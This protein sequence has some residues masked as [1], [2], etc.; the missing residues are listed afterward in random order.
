MLIKKYGS[1]NF[2]VAGQGYITLPEI[3][4]LV[5]NDV[6]FTYESSIE[7]ES[8]SHLLA[9]VLCK[10]IMDTHDTYSERELKDFIK[11]K[12]WLPSRGIR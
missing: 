6:E 2:K 4:D 1:G 11:G 12:R 10:K 8:L 9:N 7:G 3:I 5:D